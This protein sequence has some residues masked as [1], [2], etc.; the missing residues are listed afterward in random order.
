M[1]T[2]TPYFAGF[3]I[4]VT[5]GTYIATMDL[6]LSSSWNAAY[7]SANGGTP[8]SAEVAFASAL[9]GDK[10]YFNIHST[11][12]PGG[13]IRGFLVPVPEP[14]SMALAGLGS[15]ALLIV[16]RRKLK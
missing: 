5:S 2:T 9:A 1:A 3:P 10:A 12:F 16:K 13:E 11:T 15:V 6:T 7:I 14:S 4:G 8:G